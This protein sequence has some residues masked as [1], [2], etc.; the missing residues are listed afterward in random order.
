MRAHR[1][2]RLYAAAGALLATVA[3]PSSSV[4]A[5][6]PAPERI[7][8]TTASR[9]SK[10]LYTMRAD[11][12]ERK[13]IRSDISGGD[14][15]AWSP[16]GR[17]IVFGRHKDNRLLLWVADARG[18]NL[19]QLTQPTSSNFPNG[20]PAWSPD[21]AHIV[22]DSRGSFGT[23]I[24]PEPKGSIWQIDANGTNAKQLTNPALVQAFFPAWSPDSRRLTFTGARDI[25]T[26]LRIFVMNADGSDVV[27]ITTGNDANYFESAWSPDGRQIAFVLAP[28]MPPGSS[29]WKGDQAPP[30]RIAVMNADG[31]QLRA[32][33]APG[34]DQP[35]AY[36]PAWTADGS[37]LVF[38]SYAGKPN[39]RNGVYRLEMMNAD[40]SGRHVISDENMERVV[41]SVA[42]IDTLGDHRTAAVSG[43]TPASRAKQ[44]AGATRPA[45]RPSS[46]SASN[47]R[48]AE[49]LPQV[50][51]GAA[52]APGESSSSPRI[53]AAAR[54]ASAGSGPPWL[55]FGLTVAG[56]AALAF[57]SYFLRP[58]AGAQP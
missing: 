3:V 41:P 12:S 16:D 7:A 56:L 45:A 25:D 30:W 28:H 50:P 49:P 53:P 57:G 40:G 38:G 6:P 39:D 31:S 48:A 46:L 29:G 54:P 55:P 51:G 26:V 33:T 11:G 10:G 44:S 24:V 43:A 58:A 32:L 19:R 15:V 47:S 2:T 18:E 1:N 14:R 13:L 21:G 5:T 42:P 37:R 22:Y 52:P 4:G 20:A 17:E 9:D 27:P 35:Y 34:D 36:A 8:F 23:G